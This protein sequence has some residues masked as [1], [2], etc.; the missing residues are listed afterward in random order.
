MKNIVANLNNS[1]VLTVTI[2][3]VNALFFILQI[4]LVRHVSYDVLGNY[5]L[6]HTMLLFIG[7]GIDSLS[8]TIIHAIGQE[9][10]N[11][12]DTTLIW[13][14]HSHTRRYVMIGIILALVWIIALPFI[15]RLFSTVPWIVIAL[16][17]PAIFTLVLYTVTKATIH[18]NIFFKTI[19]GVLL[20]E[21]TVKA[22]L[23]L[24]GIGFENEFLLYS[25]VPISILVGYLISRAC[26][27]YIKKDTATSIARVATFSRTFFISILALNATSSILFAMDMFFAK[28]LLSATEAGQ[29]AILSTV[30]K[31]LFFAGTI[32]NSFLLVFVSNTAERRSRLKIFSVILT[33]N[34]SIVVGGLMV[35][36]IFGD[37]VLPFIF[38]EKVLTVSG[39]VI[40]Y[41]ISIACIVV[42]SAIILFRIIEHRYIFASIPL[43]F[44]IIIAMR[45]PTIHTLEDFVSAI[46]V[47]STSMLAVTVVTHWYTTWRRGE[48]SFIREILKLF[49]PP[50]VPID[51]K[52]IVWMNRKSFEHPDAGGAEV[53]IEN[54]GKRIAGDVQTILVTSNDEND[55]RMFVQNGNI[56]TIKIGSLMSVFVLLPLYYLIHLRKANVVLDNDNAMPFFV[57]LYRRSKTILIV[58]HIHQ[59]VFRSHLPVGLSHVACWIEKVVLPKLYSTTVA[60]SPSTRKDMVAIGFPESQITLVPNGV[61]TK[62]YVPQEARLPDAVRLITYCGRLKEYKRIHHLI[63][64]FRQA[65]RHHPDIHLAI[66]GHGNELH[67][68]KE[69]ARDLITAGV[70]T[71][72]GFV[73]ESDK[74]QI[75]QRTWVHVLPSSM[76]GWGITITESGACRVPTIG[77]AIPGVRDAIIHEHTG[78]LCPAETIESLSETLIA[79]LNNPETRN[80]HANNSHIHAQNYSWDTSADIL[81]KL[82]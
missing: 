51:N 9:K 77:Y 73:S 56:L 78:L 63:E 52:T 19:A 39:L 31:I 1:L 38:G 21:A 32:A 50:P 54:I 11:R 71:F 44:I 58:H 14:H 4:L 74:I 65:R 62:Q 45:I 22:I 82:L 34:A 16:W 27:R 60:I 70:C 2:V 68:L 36:G 28:A 29:Y 17:T 35:F 24:S 30:G 41:L 33:I 5:A 7:I 40:P 20:G 75:Y 66:V 67:N 10:R 23:V 81:K 26:I 72:T 13:P 6:I 37:T 55:S 64:A 57:P 80:T 18:G 61:D 79:L 46:L 42:Y 48:Y 47:S 69:Q 59:R 76:E 15:T 49:T 25:S 53:Y 12:P 3:F 8:P 43:L